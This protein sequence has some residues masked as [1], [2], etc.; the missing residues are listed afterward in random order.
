M[1]RPI[2]RV[3]VG[4]ARAVGRADL[5][6]P[7]AGAL[8]DLGDAEAVA[9][10]DEL[11]ARD[12]DLAPAGERREREHERGRAVVDAD[13]RLGAGQLA[14]S[15]ATWSWREPRPPRG[16]VELEVRVAARRRPARARARPR[17]S[18]ARPRFVCR[19]TPVAFSTGRSDGS[20]AA[21]TRRRSSGASPRRSPARRARG[22]RRAPRAPR[23]RRARAGVAARLAHE[24]V[25]R[26]QR[27][28]HVAYRRAVARAAGGDLS[29]PAVHCPPGGCRDL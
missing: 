15:A 1:S 18:G 9:D 23:A 20:S 17:P 19:T 29:E 10:L 8:H 7:R 4:G 11:A 28:G 16:Q 22:A 2:A 3:V 25:D 26:R 13:R 21:R 24:R 14:T 5:A 12:D 27:A 6:Q